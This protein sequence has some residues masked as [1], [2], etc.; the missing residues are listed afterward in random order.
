MRSALIF[1]YFALVGLTLGSFINVLIARIPSGESITGRSHCPHCGS[2]LAVRDLI[3]LVSWILLRAR[4]RSCDSRISVRYPLI[5]IT[6]A[7][8]VVITSRA[9]RSIWE[10]VSWIGFVTLAVALSVID[11]DHLRLPNPL[12][13]AAFIWGLAFFA[14]D[15]LSM[16]DWHAYLRALVCAFALFAFFLFLRIASRGGM[17]LGDVK[18]A[19]VTGFFLGYSSVRDLLVGTFAA[20]LLGALVGIV[21][22]AMQRAGRKT[23]IPFG[24]F[25]LV[26]AW[27]AYWLTPLTNHLF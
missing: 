2:T 9:D 27:L 25:M 4:C 14:F 1:A 23:P 15:S 7:V 11:L 13:L 16:A 20:F 8:L 22:M 21:L 17:G 5:E 24:P 18:L 10:L 6:T 19:A 12:V 3:P 26:G